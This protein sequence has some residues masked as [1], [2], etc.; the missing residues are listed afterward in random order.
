MRSPEYSDADDSRT[1]DAAGIGIEELNAVAGVDDGREREQGLCVAPRKLR[2]VGEGYA[3]AFD[4]IEDEDVMF[5]FLPSAAARV[6]ETKAPDGEKAKALTSG[7]VVISPV[8]RLRTANCERTGFF[9]FVRRSRSLVETPMRY[10][11]HFESP[12]NAAD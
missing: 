7:I 12:E 8:A 5:T 9:S 2:D 11:N 10:A 1:L 4:E 6:T 3:R